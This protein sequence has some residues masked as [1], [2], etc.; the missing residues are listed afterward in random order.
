MKLNN[1]FLNIMAIQ[2]NIQ[3]ELVFKIELDDQAENHFK[4]QKKIIN[5]AT[6]SIRKLALAKLSGDVGEC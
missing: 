5:S 2:E 4:K 1:L 6:K 3:D